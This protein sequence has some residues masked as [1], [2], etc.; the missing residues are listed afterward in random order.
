MP[1]KTRITPTAQVGRP[2]VHS[3]ALF[4][5]LPAPCA[6]VVPEHYSRAEQLVDKPQDEPPHAAGGNEGGLAHGGT[7]PVW[8]Q[9]T[10]RP[11]YRR[12]TATPSLTPSSRAPRA[13]AH[14]AAAAAMTEREYGFEV[15]ACFV[16]VVEGGVEEGCPVLIGCPRGWG[17]FGTFSPKRC[18]KGVTTDSPVVPIHPTSRTTVLQRLSLCLDRGTH[19]G[20][21]HPVAC[22]MCTGWTRWCFSNGGCTRGSSFP[23]RLPSGPSHRAA[24]APHSQAPHARMPCARG[25]LSKCCASRLRMCWCGCGD[26]FPA[27]HLSPPRPVAA[28]PPSHPPLPPHLHCPPNHPMPHSCTWDETL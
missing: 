19:C 12:K 3:P 7:W 8:Y 23:W 2:C 13:T 10:V 22:G 14:R 4:A 21:A 6:A 1:L 17:G 24:S 5:Q 11:P 20:A 16:A 15:E 18:C 28:T 26:G 27:S 9:G 25:A